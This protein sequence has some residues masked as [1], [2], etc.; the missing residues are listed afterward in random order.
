[1]IDSLCDQAGE[2]NATV[3]CF[4]FDFADQKDQSPGNMMGALLKQAVGGLEEIPEEIS[5]EYQKQ[6]KAIGGRG[7]RLSEIVKMLRT[8]SAKERTFICI[9][10]IDECVPEYRA[11]VLVSLNEILQKAPGVRIFV[12][13]RP[14]IRSEIG[15][16]LAGRVVSLSISTKRD[17]IIRYLLSRLEEDTTPDAMDSCLEAE[18]LM[19]IPEDVSEM[20]V[21]TIAP[22]KLQAC[23]D[24]YIYRFLLVALNIDAVLQET[25][26]HRRR[27][28]L[29]SMTYGL[30]LGDA[31][32]V[33]LDRIK[34]QGEE[35]ARLGMTTL[36]W[37]SHSERPLKADELCHALAVEIGSPD[38]NTDNVPSIGTLLT[39][40]QGL[41]VVEKEAST[42]RL[43]HFTLKEYLRAHLALF[44]AAH[45]VM[46]ETCLSYLNSQPV[47]AFST[48]PSPD[49]QDVPFLEY[50]S[51]YWGVHAK[52]DLS[53][54]A[55]LLALKL[56]DDYVDHTS[57]KIL[58]KAQNILSFYIDRFSGFSG[59]HCAS[60]FG[61]VE[62][63][64]VL[65]QME[66]C[67]INQMDCGGDTPLMWAAKNGHESVVKILLARDGVDPDNPNNYGQTPL[68]RAAYNGHEGVVKILLQRD[69]V[70]PDKPDD[71]GQT[72]LWW[73][74]FNGHEGVVK[75][76]LERED[77]S[78]DKPD[79]D[80]Q[81][82]LRWAAYDGH[83]GVVKMLLGRDSVSPDKPDGSG[84]TPLWWAAYSGHQGVVKILLRQD[85]V[86]PDKPDNNCRTPLRSAAERGHKGVVKILLGQEGV[87]PDKPDNDGQTPLWR[88]AFNGHEGVVGILLARDDVNPDKQ[89]DTGQTPLW[90]AACNGHEGVVKILL[91]QEGVD[92]DKPDSN[93]RT[94]FWIAASE[95]YMGVVKI[96]LGQAGVSPDKPD[97][98]GQTPLWRS[99]C[100]GHEGVVQILLGRADVNPDKPDNANQTP[101]WWAAFYGHEGVVKIL[102]GRDD[103]NPDK[104]DNNGRTPFW[105][106]A[107]EGHEAV[108]KML[109]GQDNVNPDKPNING[110]TPLWWAA[111]DGY[112]GVVKMLLARDDVSLNKPDI[113]GETPLFWAIQNGHNGVIAL[114][115]PPESAALGM[116]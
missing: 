17:D 57:A 86:S 31:Y 67:D 42:V 10:A 24:K 75:L 39:C 48:S 89:D 94:P 69:E 18:I 74:A 85:S 46:A 87:S 6:K 14:H 70:S 116:S 101:L 109:L 97:N 83:E 49:L 82:P 44:S 15:T 103:V 107:S 47:K 76:L 23:T 30:G 40:C 56:F 51:L 41:V 95:G 35:K 110:R 27:Q 73:A 50:S 13:G 62:I 63:V 9:D 114:L 4:Y 66:G 108:V 5:Q 45:S 96:L 11:K 88:A 99:A 71:A 81:T 77:V 43:I 92:P 61:I 22:E 26:I 29:N 21:Q 53:D 28:K 37:I 106:A 72:P 54:C 93:G 79:N 84:R 16:R 1:V 98:D 20:Y 12:T 19:K 32:S 91:G 100:N 78:P 52:R 38:L 113:H 33:T 68:W 59:L 104:P 112:V 36:M 105:I 3:A 111:R 64:T 80:G 58:M 25:T 8:T 60:F 65:V 102:L 115:Q 55:K 90:R 2:Q 7:L 34:R